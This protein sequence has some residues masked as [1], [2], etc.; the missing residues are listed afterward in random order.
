MRYLIT[1]GCG[2]LGSNL[3]SEVLRI[4][5]DL[6]IFDNLSRTGSEENLLWLK[7][8]GEFRFYHGDIRVSNDIEF[9]I[10]DIKPDI[11]FH[12]AGQVAMTLSLENPRK[13]FEINTMGSLNLLESVR[14]YSQDSIVLY[15]S[16]NKVY[17]DL[18]YLKYTETKT[19][20]EIENLNHGIDE[21]ASLDFRSPY[22]C[23]KGTA[24]QY[25]LDY[26]RNFNIRTIVFRHSTIFGGRQFSTFDQGWI[27]WFVEKAIL[28][29]KN[30][31]TDSFSISGSGKQ[32][33][34][35]LFTSDLISCYF[36]AVE[37]IKTCC[38]ESY[39]IG[40]GVS[41]SLSL[42]ELFDIL[43]SEL[44]VSLLHYKIPWRAND[45]KVFIADIRK[46]YSDF[47]WKPEVEKTE[48]IIKM[49]RWIKS[50]HE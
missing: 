32:V 8:L 10:K 11:I 25:M 46:A 29:E 44:N 5:G 42:I 7:T 36:S 39:N 47:S 12:L 13:D 3:A 16:T 50:I 48:G 35:I 15:S 34:D 19:R 23:S 22:G 41:N 33:R 26:A 24:D 20:Y 14:K 27:G 28:K 18:E 2:F 21:K 31:H 30:P 38:G 45:Q 9:F 37:N 4:G 6:F 49:I 40:G 1:G 17:G 43:E